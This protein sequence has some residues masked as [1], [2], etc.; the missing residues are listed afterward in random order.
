MRAV[1]IQVK[2]LVVCFYSADN[3]GYVLVKLVFPDIYTKRLPQ[4]QEN[5]AEIIAQLE[6]S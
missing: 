3:F 4:P 1:R 2:L 6:E 5:I